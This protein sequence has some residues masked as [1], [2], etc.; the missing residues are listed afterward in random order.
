MKV[1]SLSLPEVKL[2]TL[3]A[4]ADDRGFF[5]EVYKSENYAAHDLPSTFVQDNFSR[6]KPG[7]V[8]GLHFQHPHAQGK[9]VQVLRG[10]IF[11]VAVDIRRGSPRFGQWVGAELSD[12]LQQQIYIPPGFAHGFLALSDADVLYKCTERYVKEDDGS[13]LWNDPD[14]S[15]VWPLSALKPLLSLKD[16]QAPRLKD[17]MTL[18]IY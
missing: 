10:R 13:I 3:D 12:S 8:R 2:L 5:V 1:E 6:S 16:T 18:P 4:F 15:I 7:T 11:D 17:R 9:L 14:L